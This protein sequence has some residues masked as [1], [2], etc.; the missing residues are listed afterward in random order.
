MGGFTAWAEPP[1]RL[2]DTPALGPGWSHR[3]LQWEGGASAPGRE[4][5]PG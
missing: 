4:E 2:P 1:Q 3:R 5:V